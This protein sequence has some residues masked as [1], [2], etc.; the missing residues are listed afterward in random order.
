LADFE[1]PWISL[2]ISGAFNFYF[3]L[4]GDTDL[5]GMLTCTVSDTVGRT[6][7]GWAGKV[8]GTTLG[9]VLFGPAGAIIGGGVGAIGGA[10][11]GRRMAQGFRGVV[12]V[13]SA[14]VD[15][16][17]RALAEAAADAMPDKIAAWQ[18]KRDDGFKL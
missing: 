9:L 2:G 15:R 3:L 6:A 1:V 12:L 17:L 16:E 5:S 13:D 4:K 10:S 14:A 7:V 18:I 11:V 8:A